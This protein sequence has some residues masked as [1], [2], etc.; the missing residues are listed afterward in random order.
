MPFSI[1]RA[2]PS[3]ILDLCPL[4]AGVQLQWGSGSHVMINLIKLMGFR[5]NLGT[6][7]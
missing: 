7:I 3:L 1:F 5:I 4:S 6:G 2:Q